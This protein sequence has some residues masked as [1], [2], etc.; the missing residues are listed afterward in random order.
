MWIKW[1]SNLSTETEINDFRNK[2]YG[3]KPVLDRI[4]QLLDEKEAAIDRSE[5]KLEEYENPNW[6]HKQA[7]KNGIRAACADLRLLLTIEDQQS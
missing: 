5:I 7:F 6:S 1:T 4:R 3:A 2:V